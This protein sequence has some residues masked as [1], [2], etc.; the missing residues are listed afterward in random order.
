MSQSK[1]DSTELDPC[2]FQVTPTTFTNS[3]PAKNPWAEPG[4]NGLISWILL[5]FTKAKER[6][7]TNH[8]RM[9]TC[10]MGYY[11]NF[12][13]TGEGLPIGCG[14]FKQTTSHKVR[15][16]D[17]YG[18]H[19]SIGFNDC[20]KQTITDEHGLELHKAV[21]LYADNGDIWMSD[22]IDAYT[23]MYENGWSSLESSS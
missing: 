11:W 7:A 14:V 1:L 13:F 21:D 4:R 2:K 17:W 6:G 23:K 10:E 3:W 8:S 18:S 16:A 12:T 9:L 22:F 5:Y 15:D 20:P 19:R